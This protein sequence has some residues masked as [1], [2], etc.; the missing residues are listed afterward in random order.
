MHVLHMHITI[1]IDWRV[2]QD[3]ADFPRS[4]TLLQL[5]F[6]VLF[7]LGLP[8]FETIHAKEIM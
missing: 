2:L 3:A 1:A 7:I 8:Y 6:S 4:F 5:L